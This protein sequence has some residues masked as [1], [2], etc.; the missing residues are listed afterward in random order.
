VKCDLVY[1]SWEAGVRAGTR[2]RGTGERTLLFRYQDYCVDLV[3]Q[4][5]DHANRICGQVILESAC[6]P[7][8]SAYVYLGDRD[9]MGRTDELGQFHVSG[10]SGHL[11][12]LAPGQRLTCVLPGEPR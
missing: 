5:N 3:L 7:V 2:G 12:I 9:G 6:E 1:D 4:R 10:P 11:T 8:P